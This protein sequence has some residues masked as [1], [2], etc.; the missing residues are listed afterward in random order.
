MLPLPP[1]CLLL[2][3]DL[4]ACLPCMCHPGTPRA[5]KAVSAEVP[6]GSPAPLAREDYSVVQQHV[7]FWDL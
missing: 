5:N 4:L 3:V 7:D 2:L 6:S 1:A